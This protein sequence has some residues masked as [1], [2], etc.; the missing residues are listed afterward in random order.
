M[1]NAYSA[2][3]TSLF[4]HPGTTIYDHKQTS[5]AAE[6]INTL[7]HVDWTS[8]TGLNPA[9]SME[10]FR[11]VPGPGLSSRF[12]QFMGTTQG[13]MDPG[14]TWLAHTQRMWVGFPCHQKRKKKTYKHH[15][16][17][18]KKNSIKVQT[19]CKATFVKSDRPI[20]LST[21]EDNK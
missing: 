10:Y 13:L 12:T 16:Q 6:H 2:G 1:K 7:I 11:G 5:F 4:G 18:K 3:Q 19:N 8:F 17:V 9:I 20:D 14:C 15:L 21:L